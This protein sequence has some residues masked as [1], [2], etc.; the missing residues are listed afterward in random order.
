M[1]LDSMAI[2]H[3]LY[4]EEN[5]RSCEDI[6]SINQIKINYSCGVFRDSKQDVTS[7]FPNLIE[8]AGSMK[9]KIRK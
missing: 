6:A 7:V 9:H 3:C 1:Q 4:K 8:M 5:N 2:R